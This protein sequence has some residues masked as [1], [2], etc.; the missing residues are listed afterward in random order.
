VI[1][2]TVKPEI[3]VQCFGNTVGY[4]TAA[5]TPGCIRCVVHFVP[6]YFTT[7]QCFSLDSKHKII[8]KTL[9]EEWLI[10]RGVEG[11]LLHQEDTAR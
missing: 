7:W 8:G 9:I 1:G 6:R 10:T 2:C 11:G 4:W 3:Q 5:E